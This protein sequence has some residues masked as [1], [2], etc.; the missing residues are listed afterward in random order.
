MGIIN[1]TDDSFYAGS[2]ITG[3]EAIVQQA[4]GMFAAGAAM[5]DI[6]GQS[7]RPGAAQVGEQEELGRVVPAIEAIVRQMPEALI[8]VD[9][10]HAE[11]AKQAVAAGASLVNDV[12]A[13]SLDADMLQT[14]GHLGV[15]F[16]CMHMKGNPQNMQSLAQYTDVVKEVFDYFIR[17]ISECKEAGIHDVIIDPGFGF[18]KTIEQN[19]Q[20][21]NNLE[22]FQLL[23]RPLLLGV[24]RKSTIYKTLETTAE[25]ALN[26]TTVLNTI[27]LMKGAF[28]LRVHDVKEA[29][30]AVKLVTAM[31][32]SS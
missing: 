27:G 10:Y 26:G 7:T 29:T 16:V 8:S 25:N 5:V 24:S 23:E 32:Q 1:A 13:G 31:Q 3:V 22:I 15:P 28:I 14:V 19:F 30:E 21:L 2:R 4:A 11:V 20:L 9:T 12:S 18:A 6:G 17:R